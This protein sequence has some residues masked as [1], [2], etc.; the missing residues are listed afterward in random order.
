MTLDLPGFAD[1]VRDAQAC[2]RAVL[3]ALTRPGTRHAAGAGL[4]APAPLHPATAALLLTLVDAETSL[5]IAPAFAPARDW[6]GFHCGVA[7]AA[8]ITAAGFVLADTLPPLGSL[9]TGSDEAPETS[10]TVILQVAALGTGQELRLDGPGLRAPASL[11]VDG[12]PDGFVALWAANHALF[13]R[14]V[15]LILCSGTTVAALP[16]T[17]RV[18]APPAQPAAALFHTMSIAEI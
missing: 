10:A 4:T 16:R 1:P 9:A 14:G 3:D 13:P 17:V 7:P 15:D 12:L 18:T 8:A 6:I 2:F 5:W 11:A